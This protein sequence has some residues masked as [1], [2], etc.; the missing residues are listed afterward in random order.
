MGKRKNILLG[1]LSLLSYSMQGQTCPVN[2]TISTN[3]TASQYY[4]ASNSITASSQVSVTGVTYRAAKYVQLNPGFKTVANTRFDAKIGNCTDPNSRSGETGEIEDLSYT[5][6]ALIV[7]PNPVSGGILYI[8]RSVASY[9][10][11]NALGMLIFEG[12]NTDKI[13]TGGLS[14]GVYQLNLEGTIYKVIIE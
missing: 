7:Y 2:T 12:F 1:L 8:N 3:I 9:K 14:S 5:S 11:S 10:I 13:N 4:K 6:E